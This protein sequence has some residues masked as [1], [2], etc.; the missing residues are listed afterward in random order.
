MTSPAKDIRMTLRQT[1]QGITRASQALEDL[2]E[3]RQTGQE[4]EEEAG[5]DEREASAEAE[6]GE[7]CSERRRISPHNRRNKA[8]SQ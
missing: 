4:A 1:G 6:A 3:S 8:T 5:E 2:S 7:A